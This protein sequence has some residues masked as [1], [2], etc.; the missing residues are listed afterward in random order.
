MTISTYSVI[1]IDPEMPA[2]V[3]ATFWCDATSKDHALEQW[4]L[5]HINCELIDVIDVG[6]REA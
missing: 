2:H 1:F 6:L 3:W 5:D 4:G